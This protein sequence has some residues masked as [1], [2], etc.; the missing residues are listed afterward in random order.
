MSKKSSFSLSFVLGKIL[1]LVGLITGLAALLTQ[2]PLTMSLS[3]A[4]GRGTVGSIVF[5]FSF[6]TILSNILAV[7]C[8]AAALLV[9]R[10]KVLAFFRSA[11]VQTA[12]AL[13]MLVVAIIYIGV[14]EALWS[15]EGLMRVLDVLLHYVMPA[16]FLL[17]W[18][19][20]V[21][22]GSASYG[23]PP[24]WLAFPVLYVAYVMIRGALTGDYPYPIMDAGKLGYPAALGNTTLILVLFVVLAFAFVAY[25]RW[26]GRRRR[27][28]KSG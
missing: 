11:K 8:F 20:F 24:K 21:R 4:A 6:F 5:F 27:A 22:K 17:H 2:F 3:L 26:A 28:V 1:A 19:A 10:S 9:G 25:D 7:A 12:V 23:D 16:L 14:L 18:L 13:Y 15:P